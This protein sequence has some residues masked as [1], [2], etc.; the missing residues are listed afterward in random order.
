MEEIWKD[1]PDYEGIY[2]ASNLGNIKRIETQR[3]LK[4]YVNKTNGYAYIHLSKHNK[5]KVLRVH[6]LIAKTFIENKNNKPYV[7]HKDGNKL[8]NNINN[9]EWCSQKENI[10]HAINV[11]HKDYSKNVYIMI[12]KNEK[13]VKRSDGKIYNSIKEAKKDMN[14]MNAHIVEVCQKKLKKTCGYGWEYLESG[15]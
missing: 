8:N 3:I 15:D 11:L 4:K 13:K 10:Q 2:Q 6:R 14:N 5:T 12:K 7:N 1:I 9:L